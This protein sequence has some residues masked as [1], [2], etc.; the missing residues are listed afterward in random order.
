MKKLYLILFNFLLANPGYNS[1]LADSANPDSYGG[2]GVSWV[3][4]IAIMFIIYLF[5]SGNK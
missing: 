2:G 1:Y 3:A 5:A 4:G